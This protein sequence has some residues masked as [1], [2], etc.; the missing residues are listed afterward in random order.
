MNAAPLYVEMNWTT[1][2]S[3]IDADALMKR[4]G[5]FHD[6]CLREAHLWTGYWVSDD[7]S[8]VCPDGLHNSI[9]MLIQRQFENPSAIELLFEEVT[10]F[11]LVCIENSDSI[12]LGA[13]LLV[14][15]GA[16]YWSPYDDWSLSSSDRDEITWLS[17]HKLKWREVK[18]LGNELRYGPKGS[19]HV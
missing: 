8:M 3:Q 10:R 1:V 16:V 19:C 18:G 15:D 6:G 13:T 12:I 17:S 5:R 14:Q 7:L 4:F 11:N 9:R 2:E